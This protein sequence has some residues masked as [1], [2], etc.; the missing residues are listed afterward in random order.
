MAKRP[1]K[2]TQRRGKLD[3]AKKVL[4]LSL[5]VAGKIYKFDPDLFGLEIHNIG[6]LNEQIAKIPGYIAYVGQVL[7][8]AEKFLA[9]EETA[10]DVWL[11]D[12]ML[13]YA[14]E[15]SES[16]KTTK[17]RTHHKA[18][19]TRWQVRAQ[20][21]AGVVAMLKAYKSGLDAKF[22]LSQTISANIRLERES[23]YYRGQMGARDRSQISGIEQP[24]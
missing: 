23:Y 14:D 11:A 12:K 8:E 5:N 7:G 1:M 13:S 22:A 15:K 9:R 10:R 3:E 4:R 24:S 20:E 17:V 16:A 2:K 18:D 6:Q 19:Y 21:A